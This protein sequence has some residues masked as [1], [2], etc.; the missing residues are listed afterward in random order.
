M[1]V[2]KKKR[3]MHERAL[4]HQTKAQQE[5]GQIIRTLWFVINFSFK[6]LTA[7]H[8][9]F[10]WIPLLFSGRTFYFCIICHS[11]ARLPNILE[12]A[13]RT[14]HPSTVYLCTWTRKQHRIYE[15]YIL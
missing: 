14:A 13:F 9:I 8:V 2:R 5:Y 3:R 10:K 12:S 15:L 6:S 4:A 11:R 7:L 1:N